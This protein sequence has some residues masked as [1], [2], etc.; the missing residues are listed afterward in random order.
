[1]VFIVWG[2]VSGTGRCYSLG[3]VRRDSFQGKPV[4]NW[5]LEILH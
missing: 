4:L 5:V 3:E 2:F 1:M